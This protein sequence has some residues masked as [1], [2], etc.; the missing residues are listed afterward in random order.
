MTQIG[1]LPDFLVIGAMKCGT[2]TLQAQLA[3]QGG[4]F[5]SSPKEP[6]YFSDDEVFAQGRDWYEGLFAAAPA[7]ALKGEAS[8]HYTKLPTYPETLQRMTTLLRE[9]KFVYMIRNPVARAISHYVHEW[10]LRGA[11]NDPEMAFC[12]QSEFVDYGCY[13]MQI[14]P[15]AD[16]YGT[17]RILLTCLEA[18]QAD[19]E[20]EFA[21]VAAFLPLPD[22]AVWQ[23]NL[24]AQNVSGQRFRRLPFQSVLV[25]NPLARTLRYALVPKSVREKIRTRRQIAKRP[26]IPADIEARMRARFLEDREALARVFPDHPAL[27]LCYPFRGE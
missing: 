18:F 17:D 20:A 1:S 7:G 16:T 21:R 8:T 14:A 25:D 9:P 15:F 12:S 4:V 3:V 13:G 6:N 5:M 24:E 10:S 22:G 11:G 19:P 23:H 2:T 27:D 26:Q